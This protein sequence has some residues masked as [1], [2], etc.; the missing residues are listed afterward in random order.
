MKRELIEPSICTMYYAGFK[1]R[2]IQFTKSWVFKVRKVLQS[3]ITP[4]WAVKVWSDVGFSI[5]TSC[6]HRE[7]GEKY[8]MVFTP[9]SACE[10]VW[11][12]SWI[13]FHTHKVPFHTVSEILHTSAARPMTEAG[14]I[15]PDNRWQRCNWLRWTSKRITARIGWHV[16]GLGKQ[17]IT[18]TCG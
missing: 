6:S 8:Q 15:S 7:K 3:P 16:P 2:M 1:I 14:V 9:P 17:F 11:A 12:K 10:E 4:R 13:G 5:A 18:V